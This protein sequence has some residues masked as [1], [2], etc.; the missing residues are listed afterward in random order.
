MRLVVDR[1]VLGRGF[2]QVNRVSF[3]SIIL[4][5]L[6]YHLYLHVVLTGG[7]TG[8]TLEHYKKQCSFGNWRAL[9]GKVL[10]LRF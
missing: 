8:K 7:Q 6:Y 10:S 9:D 5:L 1:G 2:Q 3:V 4:P